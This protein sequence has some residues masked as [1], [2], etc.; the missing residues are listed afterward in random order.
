MRLSYVVRVVA[1]WSCWSSSHAIAGNPS[2][3]E[4][5]KLATVLS[6]ADLSYQRIYVA[7]QVKVPGIPQAHIRVQYRAPNFLPFKL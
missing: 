7:G 6:S 4:L 2:V 3:D 5:T 1:L